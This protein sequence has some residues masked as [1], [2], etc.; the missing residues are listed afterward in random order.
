MAMRSVRYPRSDKSLTVD[1]DFETLTSH[2]KRLGERGRR[3]KVISEWSRSAG[4]ATE[5]YEVPG[6]RQYG[7]LSCPE[8]ATASRLC[9]SDGGRV[10][11]I[12]VGVVPQFCGILLDGMVVVCRSAIG[13]NIFFD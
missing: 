8:E 3:K 6:R 5:V 1:E 7:V 12:N 9:T 13:W 2:D 11:D 4:H 10:D